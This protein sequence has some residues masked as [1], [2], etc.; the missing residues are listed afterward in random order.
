MSRTYTAVALSL[1]GLLTLGACNS[2]DT[3]TQPEQIIKL[4]PNNYY[5][6]DLSKAPADPNSANMM[7]KFNDDLAAR[8]N[9]P[10]NLGGGGLV[11][12]NPFGFM[13][14]LY[15]ANA[16]T[17]KYRVEFDN[18]QNKTTEPEELYQEGGLKVFVDVPIPDGATPSPGT[19]GHLGIYDPAADKLWELW[20]AKKTATGWSACWG[21][22]IDYVSQNKG[23]YP[24]MTGVTATG[25]IFPAAM[26]SVDEARKGEI[27]HAIYMA[28][29]ADV[30]GDFYNFT[31]PDAVVANYHVW[32]AVRHDG[33]G[34]D[35]NAIPEGAYLRLDPSVN[36]DALNLTPFGKMVAKAAQKYGFVVMDRSAGTNIGLENPARDMA[37]RKTDVNPWVELFGVT[38]PQGKRD[39][40]W[41]IMRNF[42]WDKVSVVKLGYGQPQP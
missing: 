11:I 31:N 19:D 17:P 5:I 16:S 33:Q 34:T 18:C 27:N 8:V 6:R 23:V 15:H 3:P 13:G 24:G 39:W 29:T 32:P 42:P 40:D 22:R 28:L 36:V 37:E 26:I 14:T 9:Y 4:A 12:V 38:D 20:V 10:S 21:G 30:A 41:N 1:T 2:V 25:L 7:K 35:P